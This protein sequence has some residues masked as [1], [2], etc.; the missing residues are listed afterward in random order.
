MATITYIRE[1]KQTAGAMKG[2]I[3]YC[4]QPKKTEDENSKRK[5]VTGVNCDG[6]NAF[7]EFL[8]TKLLIKKRTASISISTF[9]PFLPVKISLQCRHTKSLWNSPLARGQVTKYW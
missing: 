2:L 4:T 1:T 9:N 6:D 3:N 8:T 7:T 5:L